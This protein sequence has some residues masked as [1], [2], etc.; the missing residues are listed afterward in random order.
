MSEKTE[1]LGVSKITRN[2]QISVPQDMR[3][4]LGLKIGDYLAFVK[5]ENKIMEDHLCSVLIS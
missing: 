2:Y 5:E 1:T 3:K 4:E